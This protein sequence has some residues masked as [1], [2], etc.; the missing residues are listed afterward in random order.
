MLGQVSRV[1]PHFTSPFNDDRSETRTL[2]HS[3]ATHLLLGADDIH[4]IQELLGHKARPY[5]ANFLGKICSSRILGTMLN[6]NHEG[7][8]TAHRNSVSFINSLL[9]L[10]DDC[11]YLLERFLLHRWP[12]L[13]LF[14]HAHL[15]LYH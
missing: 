12:N 1:P 6:V 14:I 9:D 8:K 15:P 13:V 3:F 7:L 2:Y 10:M 5:R 11:D 4:K